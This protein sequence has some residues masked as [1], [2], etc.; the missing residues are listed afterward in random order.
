MES[1]FEPE[2]AGFGVHVLSHQA[3]LLLRK[4]MTAANILGTIALCQALDMP[5]SM[6][7]IFTAV[8]C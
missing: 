8:L 1:G 3:I 2:K 5:V 6:Y 7:L 4:I